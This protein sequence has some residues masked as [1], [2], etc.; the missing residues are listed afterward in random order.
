MRGEEQMT[1]LLISRQS[2]K[3]KLTTHECKGAFLDGGELITVTLVKRKRREKSLKN[4][5]RAALVFRRPR[6]CLE[7]QP[8]AELNLA[9]LTEIAVAS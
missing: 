3:R 4:F 2:T 8:R 7:D 1:A 6:L 9:R 5:S